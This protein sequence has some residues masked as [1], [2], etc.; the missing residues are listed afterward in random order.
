MPFTLTAMTRIILFILILH[1]SLF[2]FASRLESQLAPQGTGNK[3]LSVSSIAIGSDP[4]AYLQEIIVTMGDSITTCY[5]VD[6]YEECYVY[7]LSSL[8]GL[9][10]VN[11]GVGG[12]HSDDGAVAVES[13]LQQYSPR[14][15]TIY[16]GNNDA[17]NPY[18]PTDYVIANL[19]YMVERCLSYGTTPIIATLGPQFDDP[20]S[21][22][23]W[24]WRQP[25]INAINSGIRQ[26][27][28][29]KN[30]PLAD[31][32]TALHW[33]QQYYSDPIHPNSTGHAIIAGTFAAFIEKCAYTIN[34][35]SAS[36][37][38]IGET[39][40]VAVT[41]RAGCSWT[42][43]S[44]ASWITVTGGGS[45][46]GS[47]TVSYSVD[48]NHTGSDRTG[49]IS[50]AGQTFTMTQKRMNLLPWIEMLLLSQHELM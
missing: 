15:L 30:I 49:T 33:D 47:A 13:V 1:C 39:G 10:T 46:K 45:G 21:D 40:G 50:I 22:F 17:G 28:A 27:A 24:A 37:K 23:D 18:Y 7:R 36:H 44:N 20:N 14:Y 32:E 26:L 34:P 8:T 3:P 9:T 19:R 4:Q 11:K 29:E 41:T 6:Y 48:A 42:A 38:A 5:G 16:Y 31:I 2:S 25:Y 35:S 12:A 43:T